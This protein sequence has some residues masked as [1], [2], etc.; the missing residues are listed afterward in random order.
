MTEPD[1]DICGVGPPDGFQLF[2]PCCRETGHKGPHY[3][4]IEAGK[5][6]NEYGVRVVEW[7]E[8]KLAADKAK[9]KIGRLKTIWVLEMRGS[10]NLE[11]MCALVSYLD[12]VAEKRIRRIK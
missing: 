7:D 1:I 3:L 2:E 4:W 10:T 11:E 12:M 8:Q 5:G 9:G 6:G